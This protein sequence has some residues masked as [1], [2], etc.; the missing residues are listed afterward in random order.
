MIEVE[1]KLPIADLDT[2]KRKLLKMGFKETAVIEERDTYFDNRQGDI[3]AN[4]EALRVRETK[5]YLTGESRV[6]INFKGKKLDTRTMTREELE[7]GVE[8]GEICRNILQAIGY[9]P[10]DPEVIK[11]RTMMQKESITACLD[12]V[13]GLGGFLELEILAN[14]EEEKD[15]ALKRIENILNSLGYQ[16][17]D[18]VRMSYLY[19]LQKNK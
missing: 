17:S 4:G 12:N 16:I 15:V 8:D 2:I 13:H 10:A 11:D 14:S 5:D 1:V 6:Q 7:T 3:R 9:A 18:T 19:M